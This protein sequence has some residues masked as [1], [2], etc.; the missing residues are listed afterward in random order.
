MSIEDSYELLQGGFNNEYE[1]ELEKGSSLFFLLLLLL[2]FAY[3][4]RLECLN[5]NTSAQLE[6]M[7]SM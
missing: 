2:R 3:K 7:R 4:K 6:V 5:A 1:N